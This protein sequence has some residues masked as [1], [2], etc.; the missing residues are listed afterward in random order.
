MQNNFELVIVAILLIS[1]TPTF[2]GLIKARTGKQRGRGRDAEPAEHAGAG[3]EML[4][5]DLSEADVPSAETIAAATVKD[6]AD[7]TEA[8]PQD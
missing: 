8:T 4:S 7:L 5:N 2:V 1:L 3:A 6:A